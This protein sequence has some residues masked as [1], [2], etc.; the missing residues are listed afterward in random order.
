MFYLEKKYNI[1]LLFHESNNMKFVFLSDTHMLHNKT[2]IPEC[3]FLIHS[4]DATFQGK[5]AEMKDFGNWFNKQPAKHKIF[6]PGNHELV[7]EKHLPES[8]NWLKDEC[9]DLHILINDSITIEGIKFHG[10]SWTPYF[11]DWA[12]NGARSFS[13]AA[14][15]RKPLMRDMVSNIPNDVEI[16]IS[17][18]PPYDILDQLLNGASVGCQDLWSKILDLTKLKIH[19]FGHIHCAYGEK[20]IN[21]VKFINASICDEYYS[22]TNKPIIIDL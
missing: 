18:G 9:S 21:N 13:E 4:G 6:V 12:F 3:D 11:C 8:M 15:Y 14:L 10:L 16:L 5:F 20:F 1:K 19:V 7:F 22:A 2:V 17:H